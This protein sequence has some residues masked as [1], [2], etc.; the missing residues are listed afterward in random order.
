M[1]I[2]LL[3]HTA[4]F[5]LYLTAEL[6]I[7][8]TLWTLDAKVATT[9]LFVEFKNNLS[10]TSPTELSDIVNPFLSEFVLSDINANIPLF[11][12]SAILPKSI[13]CPS[14]GV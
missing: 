7:C 9:I 1:L 12:N 6:T 13:N 10:K 2:I 8:C 11:P 4:I 3:P 14:I 5:L